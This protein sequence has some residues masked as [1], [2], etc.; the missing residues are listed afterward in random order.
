MQDKKLEI[1]NNYMEVR[2]TQKIRFSQTEKA[3]YAT[4]FER[5]RNF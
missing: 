4:I 2:Y 5:L 3:A 1:I